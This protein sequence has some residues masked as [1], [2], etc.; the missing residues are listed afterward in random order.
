MGKISVST[1]ESW[2]EK[3]GGTEIK[4]SEKQPFLVRILVAG[5]RVTPRHS[6]FNYFRDMGSELLPAIVRHQPLNLDEG[7]SLL[8]V[9]P[10][11]WLSVHEQR[12]FLHRLKNHPEANKI[13]S[14]DIVTQEALIVGGADTN[15]VVLFQIADDDPEASLLDNEMK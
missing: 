2:F 13:A 5:Y 14:V 15:T 6:V 8:F 1:P 3:L 11:R 10:E 4:G 9:L 12:A 7:S